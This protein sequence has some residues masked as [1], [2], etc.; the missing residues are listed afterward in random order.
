MSHVGQR[1]RQRRRELGLSLRDLSNHSGVSLGH[2]SDLE[3][4]LKS[5][6]VRILAK[7][8]PPLRCR[9]SWLVQDL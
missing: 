9:P 3:N 2:L 1:V 5:P 7:I 4:G 6:T 8:G